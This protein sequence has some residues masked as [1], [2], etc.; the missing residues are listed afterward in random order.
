MQ[1]YVQEEEWNFWQLNYDTPLV[2][3]H[4]SPFRNIK[5]KMYILE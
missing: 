2:E 1:F 5:K 3:R 4:V